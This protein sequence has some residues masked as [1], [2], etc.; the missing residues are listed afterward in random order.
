MVPTRVQKGSTGY[1]ARSETQ[2]SG[3]QNKFTKGI[4][5]WEQ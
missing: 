4:P 1:D 5:V 3:P 2:L